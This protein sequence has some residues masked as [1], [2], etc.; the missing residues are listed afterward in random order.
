MLAWRMI[1]L[2]TDDVEAPNVGAVFQLAIPFL[3]IDHKFKKYFL[4][5][6]LED[7]VG[8]LLAYESFFSKLKFFVGSQ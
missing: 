8:F 1:L 6:R 5:F 3:V 4:I 2:P 7:T